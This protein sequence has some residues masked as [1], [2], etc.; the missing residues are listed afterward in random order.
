MSRTPIEPDDD[1]V[2][3]AAAVAGATTATEPVEAAAR[4]I[5][6]VRRRARALAGLRAMG[7]R[8][9]FDAL[10]DKRNLRS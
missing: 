10:L 1:P 5:L 6:A 4:E 9:D 2:A 8:G 3:D 7:A